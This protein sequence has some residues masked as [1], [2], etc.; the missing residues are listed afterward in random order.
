MVSKFLLV[1]TSILLLCSIEAVSSNGDHQIEDLSLFQKE[2]IDKYLITTESLRTN[3]LTK[4][5]YNLD[6]LES[7]QN[8]LSAQQNCYF[9]YL[10]IY[11]FS[12]KG[13]YDQS[14]K[15]LELLK[16]ACDYLPVKIRTYALLANLYGISQ[17]YKEALNNLDFVINNVDAINDKET[18][19]IAFT[20]ASIVYYQI[21]QFDLS[22]KFSD[23]LVEMNLSEIDFCKAKVINYSS[24]LEISV[25]ENS[26]T[27]VPEIIQKCSDLGENIYAQDLNVNWLK[28]R[29]KIHTSE[30]E[31]NQI[32]D[33]V[34]Q[35]NDSIDNLNYKNL[36]GLKNSLLAQL[37]AK[38]GNWI[39]AKSHA[40]L[41]ITDSMTLGTTKQKIDALQVLIDFYQDQKDY[42]TANRFLQEKN[43]DEK[44][45]YS[46][47][48]AKLM[49]YQTI[50]HD[51]LAKTHQIKSLN[52]KYK[53]LLLEQQIDEKEKNVQ[54]IINIFFLLLLVFFIFLVYRSR[55]QHQKF[56]RLSEL[57]HMTLIYNRKGIKD[58]MEYL[59][60]NSK[61]NGET[62]GFGIFDLD[63]FKSIN[64]KYGHVTG[65]W[66]IKKVVE[67]CQKINNEKVTFGRLGG[68]EFAVIMRDAT[69]EELQAFSE[70]CRQA[71]EEIVSNLEIDFDIEIT[72]SFGLTSTNISDYDY[73]KMMIH[74]DAALYDSKHAGRNCIS[75]F[76][77]YH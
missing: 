31:V 41:A 4:F 49:A 63:L 42:K 48:Q 29:Y 5:S 26:L 51:N 71:I 73:T 37:Y 34:N 33:E 40:N 2:E 20:I 67:V 21:N 55:K 43:Q 61:E 39:Q 32:F 30:D 62:V 50:K 45:L 54:K 53:V 59:L 35:V 65:D 64:D 27:E 19:S 12:I 75:I 56:K 72:A 58:H 25:E 22:I 77:G 70:Q 76:S 68:E 7:I 1:A 10:K 66:V 8:N 9:K 57:D 17:K 23:L 11:Q 14:V 47:E 6:S 44:R 16:A 46:D 69:I 38:T 18:K 74:A 24:K 36:I 15:D 60:P 3:D 52:H 13:N 28:H